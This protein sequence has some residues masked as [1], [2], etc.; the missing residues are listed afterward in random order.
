M[1][2]VVDSPTNVLRG[3]FYIPGTI[4]VFGGPMVNLF[5]SVFLVEHIVYHTCNKVGIGN[6]VPGTIIHQTLAFFKQVGCALVYGKINPPGHSWNL[7]G[8]WN[9]LWV[10]GFLESTKENTI[11]S[12]VTLGILVEYPFR[13]TEYRFAIHHTWAYACLPF[14]IE[15]QPGWWGSTERPSACMV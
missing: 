2:A 11:H 15:Q 10:T 1:R 14:S 12:G 6:M 7:P 3:L 13:T 5:Y 9:Q 4:L 8:S